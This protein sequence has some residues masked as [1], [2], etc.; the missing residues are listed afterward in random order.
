MISF[1]GPYFIELDKKIK[2]TLGFLSIFFGV[3]L[4]ASFILEYGFYL[5]EEQIVWIQGIEIL[6]ALF[7]VGKP[8]LL[9]GI[10]RKKRQYLKINYISI[11]VSSLFLVL[12][13]SSET[14]WNQKLFGSALAQL[15]VVGNYAKTVFF[16]KIFLIFSLVGILTEINKK[17]GKMNFHPSRTLVA[18]FLILIFFGAMLLSLPTATTQDSKISFVDAVFT[19]T[20]A[21]CVTGLIVKDTGKDFTTFGQM[22]ILVLI[23]L[24]G[25]GLMTFAAF[26]T[27]AFG[28]RLNLREKVAMQS[29]LNY[30]KPGDVTRVVVFILLF[31]LLME[32][33]GA[34]V[35]NNVWGME[36]GGNRGMYFSIFH[37]ISAFCNAGFSLF[38]D[39]L[40]GY[41]A[42]VTVNL[43]ITTL[44]I[45]GG[46]G[47]TVLYNLTNFRIS[48]LK[49]FRRRGFFKGKDETPSHLAVQTKLVIT[50]SLALIVLGA[51]LFFILEY[52]NT[53]T[54]MPTGDKVMASYFHSVTPRTAG[55][56]TLD[57]SQMLD[58]TLFLTILLMFIGASPISCGGGIKTVTLGILLLA[59]WT[60]AK[61]NRNIK[62]FRRTIPLTM[63][64]LALT[65]VMFS[66][67]FVCFFT[68]LLSISEP[69][70]SFITLLFEVVSAYG[71][72]G[73]SALSLAQTTALS[74]FSKV[75]LIFAMFIG[76][77]GPL[78]LVL[79]LAGKYQNEPAEYPREDVIVG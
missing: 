23:Q 33:I 59:I 32:V 66:L 51:G 57:Y 17:I 41:R 4:V 6:L 9:L 7:F 37:S 71:T 35:L 21:T 61:G 52:N 78:A 55:F 2:K 63:V 77:L 69:E 56:N 44:I 60:T 73:L 40:S 39:S 12:Y 8:F 49:F 47:F 36:M 68:L 79:A 10:D 11:A 14:F 28:R 26:F 76:R 67:I 15:G 64:S 53:L 19:A 25:L 58:S 45:T 27:L 54:D 43:V 75:I 65:V 38:S 31:T 3:V 18:S 62:V 50:I 48:S 1:D 24:G 34:L 5:S 42:D 13:L 29:V 72:V 16:A 20:S 30:K 46:L 70:H 74:A 22:V